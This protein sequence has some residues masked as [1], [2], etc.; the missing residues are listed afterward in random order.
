MTEK[1]IGMTGFNWDIRSHGN[2]LYEK[3]Q[4]MLTAFFRLKTDA[5][6]DQ[7]NNLLC[8]TECP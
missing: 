2:F 4:S 5:D 1:E 6:G 8:L 7:P 3:R